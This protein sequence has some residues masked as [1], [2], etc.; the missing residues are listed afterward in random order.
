MQRCKSH[1]GCKPPRV[2]RDILYGV[3][4]FDVHF[5]PDEFYLR[6]DEPPGYI[7]FFQCLAEMY[8]VKVEILSSD[9]VDAYEAG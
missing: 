5:L 3:L 1:P 7:P 8:Q 9:S 2:S 6:D 4:S